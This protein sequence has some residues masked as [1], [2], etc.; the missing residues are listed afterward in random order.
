MAQYSAKIS[1][2]PNPP[3]DTVSEIAFSQMHGLMAAS[4][5]DGTIRTYDLENLYSPNSSVVSLNKP[6]LT[7]CFSK[8][9]PSLAFAGAADGSLQMVD[10]QTNQVSSFQA[11]D[12]GVKSVRCFSN[13]LITGSW[14]KTVKFWDV[15]SSKLVVSL[16]LPGKVY[17]MDLEKELLSMSLSRNEVI[18]YNLNNINQKKPHVS[19][20]NWMIRSIACA[21]DNETFAVGGIEGKAEIFN[22]NSPVK[23]MIFR[24]HRVDNKVYAVNSV[25][26]LPTNHNILV[27]AGSDGT[28]VFF[29]S[30][31][32]T[33]MFTQTESQPIT[34]G[35]FNTNGS[36]YVYATGNDWSTGYV[37]TYRPTQ[38]KA[39]QVSTTGV[40][41]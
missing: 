27:T 21:Q 24:C 22:V 15:R 40:K 28:I 11:H 7:C 20:L 38:L 30:Q 29:D 10:L 23:K 31:A 18:T 3:S 16:D 17:A 41:V 8:E 19:K 2:I 26:F 39:I 32:R 12:E 5:W 9:T 4:S 14:D 37:T 25:S 36:Y 1:D 35:R 34:Y 33:K 13:M 6:L